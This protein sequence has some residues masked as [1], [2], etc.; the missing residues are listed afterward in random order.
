MLVKAALVVLTLGL[1]GTGFPVQE[2][3]EGVTPGM[4]EQGEVI[5]SGDGICYTCHGPDGTGGL[6]A[7]DLT[8]GDWIHIDGSYPSL[9]ELI[10]IGVPDPVV[11]PGPMPPRGGSRISDDEL[12]AVAAY[13]WSLSREGAAAR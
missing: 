5:F 10:Q 1:I 8:L 9:V 11:H 7:P 3:P 13:V 12:K 2:L 6:L 4:I